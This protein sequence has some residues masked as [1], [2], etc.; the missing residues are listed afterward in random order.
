[1]ILAIKPIH[2]Y[3]FILYPCQE[4]IKETSNLNPQSFYYSKSIEKK[5]K[6][7]NPEGTKNN[8][9]KKQVLQNKLET[10]SYHHYLEEY[11]KVTR[12]LFLANLVL[13][14]LITIFIL[15]FP[16][17]TFLWAILVIFFLFITAF[18]IKKAIILLGVFF[19]LFG[20]I[21][22]LTV[23]APLGSLILKTILHSLFFSQ[24]CFLLSNYRTTREELKI[25]NQSNENSETDINQ[26]LL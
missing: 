1:M 23:A 15:L 9:K 26:L 2:F 12:H 10:M 16:V 5:V 6:I 11:L 24:L 8:S 3:L 25:L 21:A 17:F 19:I 7:A 18:I 20:L 22:T 4:S 13:W 14:I